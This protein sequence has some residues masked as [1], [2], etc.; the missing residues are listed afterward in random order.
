LTEYIPKPPTTNNRNMD[1]KKL[2]EHSLKERVADEKMIAKLKKE[3][4]DLLQ[5]IAGNYDA[6]PTV[7]KL[8]QGYFKQEFIDS[9]EERWDELGLEFDEE[10][11]ECYCSECG[12]NLEKPDPNMSNKEFERWFCEDET[13]GEDIMC[14]K[15]REK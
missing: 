7:K 12:E 2:Y 5:L 11:Y 1:Y 4:E 15:C 3:K 8:I 10:G 6:E 14:K 9:N 13:M